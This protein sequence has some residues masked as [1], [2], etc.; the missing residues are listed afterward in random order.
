MQS[1]SAAVA[2]L[3]IRSK[4]SDRDSFS[5]YLFMKVIASKRI[6]QFGNAYG[7]NA[8]PLGFPKELVRN[9]GIRVDPVRLAELDALTEVL[10][11]NK[12]EFVLELLVGGIEQGK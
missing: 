9:L 10:D 12:Q 1:Y 4:G 7:A 3:P 8:N 5:D 2:S 11:C 6:Q